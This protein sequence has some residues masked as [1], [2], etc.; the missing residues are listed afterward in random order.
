MLRRRQTYAKLRHM[1]LYSSIAPVSSSTGRALRIDPENLTF[2]DNGE[3]ISADTL[4]ARLDEVLSLAGPVQHRLVAAQ[5]DMLPRY[6]AELAARNPGWPWVLS[7]PDK[8]DRA[9]IEAGRGLLRR[10]F[11]C[12][13]AASGDH[14]FASFGDLSRV[15]GV[16][17]QLAPASTVLI[18]A[19]EAAC[20]IA[21]TVDASTTRPGTTVPAAA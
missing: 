13:V 1:I 2:T 21:R 5:H 10:D 11:G 3:L 9:L 19:R 17:A 12:I 16:A 14:S 15:V 8:A 20:R 4:G 7:G 18:T 6:G